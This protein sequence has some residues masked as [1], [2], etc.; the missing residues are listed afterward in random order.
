MLH[1]SHEIQI[2]IYFRI[3]L[4]NLTESIIKCWILKNS[5]AFERQ[6]RNVEHSE[7]NKIIVSSSK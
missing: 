7:I 4:N 1:Q 3:I 2:L 6:T 5:E